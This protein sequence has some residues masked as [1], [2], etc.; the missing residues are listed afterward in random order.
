MVKEKEN[1]TG[2]DSPIPLQRIEFIHRCLDRDK[3]SLA[4]HVLLNQY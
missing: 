1:V 3:I 2:R 4:L